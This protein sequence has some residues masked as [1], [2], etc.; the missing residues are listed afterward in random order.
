MVSELISL[1]K[2]Q[3][4]RLIPKLLCI[5]AGIFFTADYGRMKIDYYLKSE[6]VF[7]ADLNFLITIIVIALIGIIGFL[8]CNHIYKK[9][10]KT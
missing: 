2:S 1:I 7:N 9:F 6:D 3:D 8:V 4:P 10:L 5:T